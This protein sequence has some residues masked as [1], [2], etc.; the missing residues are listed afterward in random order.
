MQSGG[1]LMSCL[2]AMVARL[3]NEKLSTMRHN[4]PCVM[5]CTENVVVLVLRE[6]AHRR[7]WDSSARRREKPSCLQSH[8]VMIYQ[9]KY[10]TQVTHSIGK[11]FIASLQIEIL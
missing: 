7:G 6:A 5:N 9:I 2:L 1:K 4:R 8:N 11:Y 3:Q 10:V